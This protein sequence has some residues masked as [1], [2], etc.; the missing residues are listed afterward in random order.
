MM[1]TTT[2][3]FQQ[4][5][6]WSPNPYTFSV[7]AC[8]YFFILSV[9]NWVSMIIGR[10][11]LTSHHRLLRAGSFNIFFYIT[12]FIHVCAACVLP[13]FLAFNFIFIWNNNYIVLSIAALFVNLSF[14][15]LCLYRF[16]E[17]R[18]FYEQP[19]TLVVTYG[20]TAIL[21]IFPI[22]WWRSLFPLG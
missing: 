18:H 2:Q 13:I 1:F 6:S 10:I 14:W 22:F 11:R 21:L 15:I 16:V 17:N 8:I 3:N 12:F 4:L 5:N 7:F 9:V 20:A 19:V